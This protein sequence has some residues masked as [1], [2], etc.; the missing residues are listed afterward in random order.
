MAVHVC[1]ES[2]FYTNYSYKINMMG[3]A[4]LSAGKMAQK[5]NL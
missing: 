3:E 1:P 2:A 5:L 4:T